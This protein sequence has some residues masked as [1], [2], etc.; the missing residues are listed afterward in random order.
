MSRPRPGRSGP[1]EVATHRRGRPKDP[2]P[3]VPVP[4]AF[5]LAWRSA[6][7]SGF[8]SLGSEISCIQVEVASEGYNA[9]IACTSGDVGSF[10]RR[11]FFCRAA[12]QS[13]QCRPRRDRA[14]VAVWIR[15]TQRVTSSTLVVTGALLVVTRSYWFKLYQDRPGSSSYS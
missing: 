8:P 11:E 14:S 6:R 1:R 2:G 13:P 3:P 4:V 10:R 5:L 12:R 15:G 7:L 9:L